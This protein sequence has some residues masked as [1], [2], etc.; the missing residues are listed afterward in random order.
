MGGA[1]AGGR[2]GRA[3]L[4]LYAAVSSPLTVI[5][6][7]LAVYIPPLYG[8]LGL[9]LGLMGLVL[10]LARFS[11]VITDPIIGHLSDRTRGR[12]GRRKPW[13]VLGAPIM[14]VSTYLLFVPPEAPGMWHFTLCTVAIFL[15]ATI[16]EIPYSAWGAEL[17]G[18]YNERSRITAFREQFAL[19]GYLLA[20]SIP[21]VLSFFGHDALRGALA[22]S[23]GVICLVLPIAVLAAVWGVP[24]PPTPQAR[25]GALGATQYRQGLKLMWRNG[26]F[27]RVVIGYT[28][29]VVGASMDS[30]LSLF[31]CKHV[32]GAESVY[33]FALFM[34][35]LAGVACVPLWR[36][37]SERLGKHMALI[38]AILWYAGWAFLMP[39]LYFVP[40]WGAPGFIFLQTMKGMSVG[41]FASL[42][43]SMAAD[44]VDIDTARSGEQR[45]GLYFAVWGVV[46]KATAALAL[47]LALGA[48]DLFGFDATAD[49]A[50]GGQ[51]GGN[52][53]GALMALA[54]LYSVVPS[55]L[56][57]CT[58]PFLWTYP[59]TE[60]RQA[61]IR[62][63]LAAKA[64]RR[65]GGV[66]STA[67]AP[68]S[69]GARA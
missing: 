55:C 54:L 66:A 5:G 38:A 24:E 41:A 50:L 60:A 68:T 15:A 48:V 30:A 13:L 18:N 23:G 44:V 35:I 42:T 28:G 46:K 32:L 26:P 9:D 63:R 21:M 65:S 8:E 36:W 61:R 16:L 62:R 53:V 31:F 43:T 1:A 59:L 64:A 45:T 49:P 40:E 12:F 27:V 69:G 4:S 34:M 11:D 37:L 67:A 3:R 57:L 33:A 56:K 10:M 19:A 29:S 25:V 7:P 51:A 47:G 6:L 14:M 52:T 58:L 39:L 22:I 2:L 17:S 20:V